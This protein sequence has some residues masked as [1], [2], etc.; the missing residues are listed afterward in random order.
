MRVLVVEDDDRTAGYLVRGLTE[1]GHVVDLAADGEAALAMA[2]EG[3]YEA[4]VLDRMLPGMDGLTLVRR[5]R[6][7]DLVRWLGLGVAASG[8]VMAVAG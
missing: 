8:V 3:I 5:L 7:D 4:L 6:R 2:L 1:S